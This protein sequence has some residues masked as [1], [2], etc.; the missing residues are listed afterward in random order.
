MITNLCLCFC[1]Y[2]CLHL[3]SLFW[4]NFLFWENRI[5]SFSFATWNGFKYRVGTNWFLSVDQ[6]FFLLVYRNHFI[7]SIFRIFRIYGNIDIIYKDQLFCLKLKLHFS[8]FLV[9]YISIVF[10]TILEDKIA[11][12]RNQEPKINTPYI[13]WI[14]GYS[15]FQAQ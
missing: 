12:P 8:W 3:H 1:L 13:L 5:F 6:S 15:D 10:F 4:N 9:V 7:F 11:F 14:G 2:I